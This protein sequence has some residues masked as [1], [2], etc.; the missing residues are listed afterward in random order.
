MFNGILVI[1]KQAGMTSGDVVYHLRRKL[2]MRRIGHAGTLDPAVEGVLPIALG[3]A[4]KLIDLMHT[5]PKTYQGQGRLGIATDSYDLEG[6]VIARKPV[7]EL[8]AGSALQAGMDHFVGKIWQKPSIYSAVKVNGKHL[9]E[10][11]RAGEQVEVPSRQVEVASYQLLKE[12]TWHDET[13]DFAFQVRCGKGT[14]VRS[15]VNDLGQLLGY[16]AVMTHLVRTSAGGFNLGQAAALDQINAANLATYLHPIDDFFV[17]YPHHELTAAEWRRVKNGAWLD[18][19]INAKRV[20][21][22]YNKKV[23]AIYQLQEGRF[24]PNMMLLQN[25]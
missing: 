20:A 21:L 4:T 14:Y 13:E 22:S 7:L 18:L 19:G 17:N 9:Y 16:P 10:Y 8:I 5:R 1:N 2:Q 11:A 24:R 23:K 25:Q 15:L 3:Q 12:P 6:K